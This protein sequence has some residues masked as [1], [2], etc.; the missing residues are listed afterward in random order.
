MTPAG[1]SVFVFG[2]YVGITGLQFLLV[3]N[4]ALPMMR[5]EKTKEEWIRILGVILAV[6]AF[7]YIGAGLINLTPFFWFTVYGRIAV[8][9]GFAALVILRLFKPVLLVFGTIDLLF[10][11]WTLIALVT[12]V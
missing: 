10:A 6:V 7:Y 3:P 1:I 4:V 9:A 8:F 2:I 11:I 12:A 5:M